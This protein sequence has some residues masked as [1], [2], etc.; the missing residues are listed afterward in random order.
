MWCGFLS[1]HTMASRIRRHD[2]TVS[3]Q[4]RDMQHRYPNFQLVRSDAGMSWTGQLIPTPL[5][6]TYTIET[7]YRRHHSPQVWVRHPQLQVTKEDFKIVHIY[8]EGCLCLYANEEWRPSMTLSS[9]IVPWAA[10]WLFYY[11]MWLAT[12]LAWRRGVSSFTG[13]ECLGLV[14]QNP[15]FRW[16]RHKGVF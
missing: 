5:S 12:G 1:T 4:I 13:K 3:D 7:T 10:E 8:R 11:E 2:L 14:F 16:R 9:T 15:I 6:V